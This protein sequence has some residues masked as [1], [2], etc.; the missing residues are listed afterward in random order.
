MTKP[1]TLT[2]VKIEKPGWKNDF[3]LMVE[4]FTEGADRFGICA[5][6]RAA[7][8][9]HWLCLGD[10]R[11]LAV[12]IV[13]GRTL[14]RAVGRTLLNLIDDGRLSVKQSRRGAGKKPN[15]PGRNARMFLA[16]CEQRQSVGHEAALKA[17]AEDFVTTPD[18]IWNAVKEMKKI[19]GNKTGPN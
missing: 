14:D 11:P 15:L 18:T 4:A 5:D 16:Y 8:I 2:L 10:F 3:E 17:V 9:I 7:M 19:M 6:P 13:E 1:E 12:E